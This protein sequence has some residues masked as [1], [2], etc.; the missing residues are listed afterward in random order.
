M[1][2]CEGELAGDRREVSQI[3]RNN[4]KLIRLSARCNPHVV[5]AYL[6]L[7]LSGDTPP[8][9]RHRVSTWKDNIP[10]EDVL[11]LLPANMTPVRLLRTCPQL[12]DSCERYDENVPSH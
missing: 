9:S 12:S 1:N 5:L 4:W 3:A 2:Q 11:Q 8:L 6:A 7:E 10:R